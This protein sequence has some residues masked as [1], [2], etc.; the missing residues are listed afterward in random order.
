MPFS[1]QAC[2]SRFLY[3]A[4]FLNIV[5]A[6][7]KPFPLYIFI[8]VTFVLPGFGSKQQDIIQN[9]SKNDLLTKRESRAWI[10]EERHVNPPFCQSSKYPIKFAKIKF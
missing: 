4:H 5:H 7:N 10:Q 9:I 3:E 6:Y 8:N 2:T 1:I